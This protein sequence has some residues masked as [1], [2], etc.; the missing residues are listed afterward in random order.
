MR[1]A[2]V[3]LVAS[4]LAAGCKKTTSTEEHEPDVKTMRITVGGAGG[5]VVNV[6][7]T[8][9]VTGGPITITVNTATT[10]TVSWLNS[11]GTPDAEANGDEFQVNVTSITPGTITFTRTGD[12]AGTL[13]GT[14]TTT[15]GSAQFALFHKAE[16]H[17]DF[18]PFTVPIS[19]VP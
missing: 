5:Q 14:A 12:H 9:V 15:S 11:A 19:V 2:I 4:M 1:S 7:S 17:E 18:G 10:I 6:S 16:A 13:T 3:V 8:G